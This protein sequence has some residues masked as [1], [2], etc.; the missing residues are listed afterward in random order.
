MAR[1]AVDVFGPKKRSCF[2]RYVFSSS[3][4]TP[5][6][7]VVRFSPDSRYVA[8]EGQQH[9]QDVIHVVDVRSGEIVATLPEWSVADIHWSA[10]GETLTAITGP[11]LGGG[12]MVPMDNIY[13]SVH[14][15]D[16]RTE[17]RIRSFTS[18]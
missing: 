14:V 9:V 1:F 12:R 8:F 15:W 16:W 18:E 17:T 10:D 3:R 7:T 2:F 6:S 4:I 13:P 11:K 5:G